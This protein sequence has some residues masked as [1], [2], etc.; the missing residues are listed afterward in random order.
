MKFKVREV[1]RHESGAWRHDLYPVLG[2]EQVHS[3]ASGGHIQ[4]WLT[5]PLDLQPG[6]TYELNFVEVRD[7]ENA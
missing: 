6:K 1:A 5:A 7:G 4:L 2:Q 3:Y